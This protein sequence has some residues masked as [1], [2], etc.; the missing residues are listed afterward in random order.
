M[1]GDFTEDV[2]RF[3]DEIRHD[4]DAWVSIT[5]PCLSAIRE[6][7]D[8]VQKFKTFIISRIFKR[9]NY[10]N[11]D[12]WVTYMS[13]REKTMLSVLGV[14]ESTVKHM[15]TEMST[16]EYMSSRG[17]HLRWTPEKLLEKMDYTYESVF[18]KS[19][20]TYF[21]LYPAVLIKKE[22][23]DQLRAIV[24]VQDSNDVEKM[25]CR[26]CNTRGKIR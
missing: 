11:T 20:P 26:Y 21:P 17:L 8:N 15:M 9:M 23:L 3:E 4:A 16:G 24:G 6:L 2:R 25:N 10:K 5:T 18:S 1:S 19:A 22:Q 14:C 13:D 7:H 12:S